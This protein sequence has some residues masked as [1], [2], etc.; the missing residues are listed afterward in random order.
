MRELDRDP[1]LGGAGGAPVSQ[2]EPPRRPISAR[3]RIAVATWRPSRDGRIYTRAA[4]DATSVLAYVE[5][6]RARTGERVTITHVVGVALGWAMRA[7]PEVRSRVVFGRI[8]EFAT[9]DIG[10]AVDIEGGDDLA[11]VKVDRVDEKTPADVARELA[12]AAARLRAGQ[13]KGYSLSS[14]IVRNLP[15]WGLRPMMAGVDFVVGGLGLPALGQKGSPLGAAFISNVGMLGL[16]EAFLA[17]LP[18]ARTPLY[19]AVGAVHDAALAI[20]GEVVVRPQLVIGA[21]ADHRLIDGAHAGKVAVIL[22]QLLADPWQL[23]V[24]RTAPV[25]GRV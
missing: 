16:D 12:P 6:A 20:D 17:P 11:A 24:P 25:D 23:D 19:I 10:F 14:S 18:F 1:T 22:R 7:V 3:R 4:I 21:T 15:W 9:C 5:D 8:R 13:D 2:P